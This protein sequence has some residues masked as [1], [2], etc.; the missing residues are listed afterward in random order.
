MAVL[1]LSA[2]AAS[3]PVKDD[4]NTA[5]SVGSSDGPDSAGA[6]GDPLLAGG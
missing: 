4:G 2:C 5:A 1:L 3:A 6:G